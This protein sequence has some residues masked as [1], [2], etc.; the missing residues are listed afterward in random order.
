MLDLL[1]LIPLF[2]LLGVLLNT[3]VLRGKPEKLVGSVAAAMIGAS[4]VVVVGGFFQL[5][6]MPPEARHFE[7]E[8][9]PLDR[10]WEFLG[11]GKFLGRS[12]LDGDDAD[13]DGR[14]VPDSRLFDWLHAR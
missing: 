1:Y 9:L 8:T 6:G 13:R 4:F 2:P 5:M 12:A 14:L 11:S 10:R 7:L 3:F